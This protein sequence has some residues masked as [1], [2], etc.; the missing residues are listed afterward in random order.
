LENLRILRLQVDLSEQAYKLAYK[1]YLDA[2]KKVQYGQATMFEVT[3]LQ[4][5]YINAN[6]QWINAE[7]SFLTQLATYFQSLG[8]TLDIWDIQLIY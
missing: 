1:S 3:T 7:I 8:I 5:N 2:L 6:I 4:T